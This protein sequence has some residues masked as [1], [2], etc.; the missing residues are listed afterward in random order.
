MALSLQERLGDW[1]SA[2][3]LMQTA[4]SGGYGED[5]RIEQARN[6]AG[7]LLAECGE[8]SQARTM[9]GIDGDPERLVHCLHALEEW[10]ELSTLAKTLPQGHPILPELG[11]MFASVGMCSDAVEALIK[12]GQRKAAMDV[13]VSLNE[14]TMAVKLSREHNLDV[15][16]PSL[17]SQYVSHLLEENKPLQAVELYCKAECFLEAAKIMYR[18]A[19]EH[20]KNEPIKI[21]RKYVLAA[22]FVENHV[23]NHEREGD[24][25]HLHENSQSQDKDLVFEKPWKGAEAY[26]FLMLAQKQ[27]YEGNL[28]TALKTAMNLQSYD[29]ILD[30]ETVYSLI[31]LSACGCEAYEVCS[32]AFMKLE[33]IPEREIWDDA[34]EGFCE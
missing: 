2:L 11:S 29:D 30:Y 17:L 13:C 28:D 4:V 3:Q 25:V 24:K 8:W 22:L 27:L 31:A 7:D 14:W 34:I 12:S 21:K 9:Y 18:L 10:A 33:A 6:E 15:D 19:K 20:K 1:Q 32:K 16:V 5:W 23:R 26:H